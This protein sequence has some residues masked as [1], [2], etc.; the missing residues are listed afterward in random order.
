MPEMA[1]D[2]A[3]IHPGFQQVGGI[4][5]AQRVYRDAALVDA[6]FELGAAKG[7]LHRALAM[8]VSEAPA[9]RESRPQAGNS[10]RGLR[11]L[12]QCARSRSRLACGSGT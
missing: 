4:A 9:E 8:G 5:V 12:R 1:L 11:W 10:S 7:T 3:K 6:G 2:D